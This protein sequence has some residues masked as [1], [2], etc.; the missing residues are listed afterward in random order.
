[1]T[2]R[3]IK[4]IFAI[5]NIKLIGNLLINNTALPLLVTYTFFAVE[6]DVEPPLTQLGHSY[7]VLCRPIGEIQRQQ[8]LIELYYI[9]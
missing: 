8:M 4:Y 6:W 3:L 5:N 9:I 2:T 7:H 1:M